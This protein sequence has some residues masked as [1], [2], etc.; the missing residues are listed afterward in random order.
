MQNGLTHRITRSRRGW[1]L[2]AVVVVAS[3]VA[4]S[5]SIA[6]GRAELGSAP[7]ASSQLSQDTVA[8][9]TGGGTV[10]VPQFPQNIL[11]SFGVNAKRPAGFTGGG[12]ASGRIN[13]DQHANIPGRRV[14]AP[15]L[16]MTAA[17][18][19]TPSAN[20]TGGSAAM[21]ADCT[22]PAA[23]CPTGNASVLVYVEDNSDQGANNDVFRIFYCTTAA[24]VPPPA[25]D[26]T[27]ASAPA[28]CTAPTV[29]P[30]RTGNIQVR[31]TIT[32]TS[33][34]VPTAARAPFR[35]P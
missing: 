5:A 26:G 23:E 19:A 6:Q 17:M 2:A 27:I 7:A 13:F 25:F 4:L 33:S 29:G 18:S 16:F 14:N 35:L 34:S 24:A 20:G 21:S 30:I 12:A 1:W 8:I 10:E 15:V 32:G 11:A 22:A 3:G 9:V 28:G 31:S